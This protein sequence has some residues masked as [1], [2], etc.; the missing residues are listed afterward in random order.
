MPLLAK[1]LGNARLCS[2]AAALQRGGGGP[3]RSVARLQ[4]QFDYL[5]AEDAVH[6]VAYL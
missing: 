6:R 3:G 4:K 2:L 5:I 1:S